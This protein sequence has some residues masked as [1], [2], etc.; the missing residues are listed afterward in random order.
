MRRHLPVFVLSVV[1]ATPLVA[2]AQQDRPP[3]DEWRTAYESSLRAEY[4]WLSVAG[5]SFLEPGVNTVGSLVGSD[6]LLPAGRAPLEVG[7]VVLRDGQATLLLRPGVSATVGE[8]PVTGT[9][10]LNPDEGKPAPRVRVGHVEFHLHRSGERL[11]I[12]VRDPQSPLRT[13]FAGTRW[14]DAKANHDVVGTL[15]RSTEPRTVPVHNVLGDVE[16]YTSPGVLTFEI[17]GRALEL[18]PFA[19]SRDRLWLIFRDGSAGRE[20]YGTRFLYAEPLGGDRYRVDFNRAYNPPCAYNPHTTC[21]TPLRENVLP[22]AIQAGER[23]YQAPSPLTA[24]R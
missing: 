21:P 1:L 7:R 9:V 12:R 16:T 24:R 23:L 17:D 2:S 18:V 15:R 14:F 5:L 19:A 22:V 8:A 13:D 4:G 3:L 11:G 6:V 10:R 20:T